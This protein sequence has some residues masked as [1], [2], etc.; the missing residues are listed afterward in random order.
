[1]YPIAGDASYRRYYR[2]ISK[3]K[4]RI[5]IYAAKEKYK[6]LIAYTAINQFLKKKGIIT[7]KL[8]KHD[9]KLGVLIIE[10]FGNKTFQ[11]ILLNI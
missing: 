9:F 1:M 11:K 7:P 2:L 5:L 3:K 8:F 6:N 10:D 4:T